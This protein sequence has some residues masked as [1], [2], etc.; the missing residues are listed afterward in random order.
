M[1]QYELNATVRTETGNGPARVLRRDGKMPAVF[2]G[3]S[4]DPISLTID[5]KELEQIFKQGNIGQLILTLVIQ[6]GEKITNPAMIKEFQAH[7]VSGQFLHLDF[8]EIDMKR[9]INVMVPVTTRGI[10]KGIELGGMLQIVR[11]ELEVLCLPTAIPEVFEIDISDLDIG[12]S[13]H[14]H[15][16]PLEGDIEIPA[17]INFTVITMLSPTVEEEEEVEEDEEEGEEGAEED[18]AETAESEKTEGE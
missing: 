17:D 14:V 7:P 10:A 13:V 9:K 8:Y 1:K 6:N 12:D 11:R 16:I 2:Y 5:I 18:G 3:P 4:T 15:D